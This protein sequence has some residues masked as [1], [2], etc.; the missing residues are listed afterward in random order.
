MGFCF[1]LNQLGIVYEL[2]S[3]RLDRTPVVQSVS[4]L[5]ILIAQARIENYPLG[6]IATKHINYCMSRKTFIFIIITFIFRI[7]FIH[8]LMNIKFKINKSLDFIF[9][10]KYHDSRIVDIRT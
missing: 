3:V 5:M 4:L 2:V 8:R 6:R 10:D 9:D 7:H 1:E